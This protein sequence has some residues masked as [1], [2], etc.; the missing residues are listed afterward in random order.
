LFFVIIGQ[1]INSVLNRYIGCEYVTHLSDKV[2]CVKTIKTIR[3]IKE[4]VFVKVFIFHQ[5]IIM[6]DKKF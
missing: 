1:S 2:V 5:N 3:T 4:E 6:N